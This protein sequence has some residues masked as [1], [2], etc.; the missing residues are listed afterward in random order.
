MSAT[1]ERKD[2]TVHYIVEVMGEFETAHRTPP[3]ETCVHALESYSLPGTKY[4]E[5]GSGQNSF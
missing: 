1:D 5:A 3:S 2:S 4:T